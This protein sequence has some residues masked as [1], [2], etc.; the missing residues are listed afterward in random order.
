[1]KNQEGNEPVV[2]GSQDTKLKVSDLVNFTKKEFDKLK[3]SMLRLRDI[4][5]AYHEMDDYSDV[6]RLEEIKRNFN[7]ELQ[8]FA[9]LYAG[10]RKFK[11]DTH[12]YLAEQRKTF[13]AEAM[14]LLINGGYAQT[15]A[16]KLSY[17]TEYYKKRVELLQDLTEFFIRVE[18]MYDVYT[19]TL[20]AIIQSVSIAGKEKGN[21]YA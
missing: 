9:T 5:K 1:M 12:S 4:S 16:E 14:T 3:G 19:T 17:G 10:V 13:K 21:S 8:Y 11:G 6:M 20:Q 18:T 2:V 15:A 7:A